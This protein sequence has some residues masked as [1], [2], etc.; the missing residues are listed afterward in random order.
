MDRVPIG[1]IVYRWCAYVNRCAIVWWI[2]VRRIIVNWRII[3]RSVIISNRKMEARF[4][5]PCVIRIK[6]KMTRMIIAIYIDMTVDHD[7]LLINFLMR[8]LTLINIF[9]LNRFYPGNTETCITASQ[10]K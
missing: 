10:G 4:E 8:W 2:I 5:V 6:I 1:W 3:N 7:V 9:F